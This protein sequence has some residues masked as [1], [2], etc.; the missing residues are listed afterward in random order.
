MS[1]WLALLMLV[2]VVAAEDSDVMELDE[3]SFKDGVADK[4]IILVESMHLGKCGPTIIRVC[5]VYKYRTQGFVLILL[6]VANRWT[7]N[8]FLRRL[9]MQCDC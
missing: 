8:L 1:R 9:F 6:A 7:Q 3:D 5:F 4:D 2:A